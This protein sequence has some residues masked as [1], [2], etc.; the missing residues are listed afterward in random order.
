METLGP[1]RTVRF[2]CELLAS[3]PDSKDL[4][5]IETHSFWGEK[6]DEMPLNRSKTFENT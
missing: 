5:R 4:K 3:N 6:V 1:W 2:H